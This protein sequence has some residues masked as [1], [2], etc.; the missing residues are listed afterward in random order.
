MST[1][2]GDNLV[3]LW[4]KCGQCQARESPPLLELT[5]LGR[6]AMPIDTFSDVAPYWETKEKDR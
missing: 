5:W 6:L 4:M 2:L 1:G 3:P